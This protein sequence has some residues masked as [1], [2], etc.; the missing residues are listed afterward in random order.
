MASP[1][2]GTVNIDEIDN[3]Q[4]TYAM[5][6]MYF[7]APFVEAARMAVT[8]V[9]NFYNEVS[10][11]AKEII[12][13]RKLWLRRPYK[14][15]NQEQKKEVIKDGEEFYRTHMYEHPVNTPTGVVDFKANRAKETRAEHM[16]QFP[17]V[18]YNLSKTKDNI[19]VQNLKPHKTDRAYFDNLKVNLF[20]KKY[21]YQVR[22]QVDGGKDFYN[23]QPYNLFEQKLEKLKQHPDLYKKLQELNNDIDL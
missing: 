6:L 1:Y 14:W 16:W 23:I 11:F 13:G 10:P 17:F 19:K 12:E 15:M 20:G 4:Q 22:N 2:S 18:R 8:P 21:D 9:A 5:P 3:I 7:G